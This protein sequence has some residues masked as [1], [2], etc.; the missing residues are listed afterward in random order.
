MENAGGVRDEAIAECAAQVCRRESFEDLVGNAAGRHQRQLERFGI[1]DAGA[2][3]I[4][5]RLA[6]LFGQA[7]N[8]VGGP[9]DE[10][11]LNAQAAQQGQIQQEVAKI[12][13][14]HDRA[15]QSDDEDAVAKTGNVT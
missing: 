5:G 8:L 2:V 6:G 4:G 1:G 9:M 7:A 14:F 13:V 3:E 15:I 11:D 12:V 10:D